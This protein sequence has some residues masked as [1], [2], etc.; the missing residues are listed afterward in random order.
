MLPDPEER[1]RPP[2]HC[3]LCGRPL[4]DR[5]A[6]TWGLGPECRAKLALRAAPRP[7]EHP[8]EQDPLPGV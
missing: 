4:R 8:V 6:R 1:R 7:P 5:E 3:R 2:V